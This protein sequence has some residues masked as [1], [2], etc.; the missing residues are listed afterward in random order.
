MSI[1]IENSLNELLNKEQK[2]RDE[3]NYVECLVICSKM[4]NSK[5]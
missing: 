3:K 2:A 5:F 4:L 1:I